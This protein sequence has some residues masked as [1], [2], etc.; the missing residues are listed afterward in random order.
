MT[1]ASSVTSIAVPSDWRALPLNSLFLGEGN[2]RKVRPKKNSEGLT[3]MQSSILSMDL[4]Q[5][6]VVVARDNG[7]EVFAGGERLIN[8]QGLAE[9]GK[10]PADHPVMCRVVPEE[11]ALNASLT[12]NVMRTPMHPADEFI[13]FQG[14]IEGGTT[15]EEIATTYGVTPA[16]VTRRLKLAN[17]SPKLIEE[18]RADRANIDQ[19]MALTLAHDHERQEAIYF[20]L[21]ENHRN[22]HVLR[23][24][25]TVGEVDIAKDPLGRFVGLET[26]QAAGGTI[27]P[28]LFSTSTYITDM[29]LLSKLASEKLSAAA[30][31]IEAEGWNWV[32][33]T[34]RFSYDTFYTY[35]RASTST[36]VLTEDEASQMEQLHADIDRLDQAIEKAE[37][38]EDEAQ[39]DLLQEQRTSV[40]EQ[41]EA[42][43]QS[44]EYYSDEDKAIAGVMLGVDGNGLLR[45]ERGLLK[46][47]ARRRST[48]D[49]ENG[50]AST[51]PEA[52]SISARMGR[53]LTAHQTAAL[54]VELA[55][56]PNVAMAISLHG[57]V[58]SALKGVLSYQYSARMPIGVTMTRHTNLADE[59]PDYVDSP[60]AQ[61]LQTMKD[62]WVKR[63]PVEAEKLLTALL[64]LKADDLMELFALCAALHLDVVRDKAT[65]GKTPT[66]EL[67]R[68]LKLDMRTYWQPTADGYFKHV[69]KGVTL[70][71]VKAFAPDQVERL[72]SMK[73]ADLAAEAERLAVGT[74]WLPQIL[75]THE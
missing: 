58:L 54:Q 71:A 24:Q 55:R 70:E 4:L 36:R 75:K 42:V 50:S 48:T 31:E 6:V 18:F 67:S 51:E 66:D 57:T 49:Q 14:L 25:A 60:A 16:V 20:G 7:F 46:K 41:I 32:Q 72:G 68:V 59:A 23:A 3:G 44:L 27:R 21:P 56:N 15:V 73:R 17:L 12:E 33:A 69:K 9:M 19:M 53:Q 28:D 45:I 2:V 11:I 34:P 43:T 39:A 5:N 37:A 40:E 8:L 13:A 63:L 1:V 47:G 65:D 64:K 52:P 10:I 38:E 62:K 30:A 22:P 29:G 61:A 26:Y 35:E 74:G